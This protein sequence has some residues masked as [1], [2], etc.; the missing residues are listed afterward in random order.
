MGTYGARYEKTLGFSVTEVENDTRR[1][2]FRRKTSGVRAADLP[3]FDEVFDIPESHGDVFRRR[4]SF[5]LSNFI[6]VP[7]PDEFLLFVPLK[8][9]FYHITTLVSYVI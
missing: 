2:S 6:P 5:G 3:L 8:I 4:P 1:P 9:I 7:N